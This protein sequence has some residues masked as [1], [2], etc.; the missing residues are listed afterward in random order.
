MLYVNFH[1]SKS[2]YIGNKVQVVLDDSKSII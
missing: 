2:S 1:A